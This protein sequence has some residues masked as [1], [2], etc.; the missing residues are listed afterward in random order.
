MGKLLK[1]C[2]SCEEGFAE[3]F[4]FCPNCGAALQ[5]FE[6]NPIMANAA[7]DPEPDI[8]STAAATEETLPVSE[9]FEDPVDSVVAEPNP[10]QFISVSP[11]VPVEPVVEEASFDV[12]E[13]PK[14][15]QIAETKPVEKSFV[16]AP[17]FQSEAKYADEPRSATPPPIYTRDDEGAFHVTVIQE[18]NGKQRNLLLLGSLFLIVVMAISATLI[19]LFQKD[20]GI[21]SIGEDYPIASLIENVPAVVDEIPEPKKKDE[22]GGGGG[23]GKNEKEPVS[24]G[25]L[26]DQTSKPIRPPD[27]KIPRLTNPSLELPPPSTEGN[28]KFDKQ[29]DRWGDPNARFGALSNGTGSGGGMGSGVGTGQGSGIGT[30]AGSGTGSGSGGGNGAGNGDG[31]GDGD[32]RTPPAA[33]KGVS[34]PI[35]IISKPRAGYTE[36]ARINNVQ[37]S[38]RVRVVL[39]ANGQV[40]SVTPVTRL[41]HGLTEQAIAAA[42]QITF[43]PKK[44]NGVPIATTVTLDYGF[45]IY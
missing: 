26:A 15:E 7:K 30:G 39:L 18:K 34:T 13:V 8:L 43:E 21:N 36:A 5:T 23:G 14:T 35:R 22:G 41:P 3:R 12:S 2:N 44:V 45:N 29:Y 1:Y 31:D 27:A 17:V 38:V 42:K 25:D 19:S 28:R 11:I 40:G 37:G 32:G 10:P 9:P 20:L 24:Q 33:P 6:M 4:G 16:A